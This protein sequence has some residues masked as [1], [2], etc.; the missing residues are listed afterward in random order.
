MKKVSILMGIYN[1]EN[2]L[3]EA[4]D[5]IINQTYE[6]WELIMC[7]DGSS[8]DTYK[9]AEQIKNKDSRIILIKNE[10]N[11]G[12]S[13]SLNNCLKLATGYY[14]AR[15]DGDDICDKNR[16]EIEVKTFEQLSDDKI[17]L[18]STA[19]YFYDNEGIFG[20]LEHPE[21]PKPSDLIKASMFCH[22]PCM[23]KKSV[24]IELG[25][26]NTSKQADRVEDYDLWYRLYA[27][28]YRGINISECLYGMRDDRNAA[29]RRKFK[30]RINE[31]RVKFKILKTFGLGK[32]N[33]IY[34]IKP[35]ILGLIPKN[36]YLVLHKYKLKED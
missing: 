15:M 3:E 11:S 29:N 4:V 20:K 32:K 31:S 19:M 7:D 17:A 9:V 13:T 1:C 36:L 18:V 12:L 35:I 21:E 16:L 27:N 5:C 14:I 34:C 26:Y 33:Y 2:T 6:N 22:A 10:K 24:L 30:Y 23:M 25:G 8:D 28:G